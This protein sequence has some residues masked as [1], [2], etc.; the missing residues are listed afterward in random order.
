MVK[1]LVTELVTGLD[2]KR[3]SLIAQQFILNLI[4]EIDKV[5]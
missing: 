2:N 3:H 1:L 4:L 5:T